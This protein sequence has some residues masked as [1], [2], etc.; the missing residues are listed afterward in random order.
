MATFTRLF[1]VV[2]LAAA[3]VG[4]LTGC[5]SSASANSSPVK[6][7]RVNLP[8]S[9]RFDPTVIQVAAGTTV[10]WTNNDNFTHSV[11]VEG[12]AEHD[13]KPGES[14]SITFDKPGEYSYIC[15]FHPQNMKGKVI[16][17]A[18]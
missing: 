17:T 5:E 1:L 12:Q 2:I 18:P 15:T 4:L 11:E 9:Y 10:T 16:V 14:A 3:A 13:M 6:T 8:P 7:D